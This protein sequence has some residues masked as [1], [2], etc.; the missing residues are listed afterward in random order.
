VT[1]QEFRA[2]V[3]HVL[4]E[5]GVPGAGIALVR[6]SGVEWAGG[7]GYA[8]RDAR[9]PVTARTHFRA[10]SISKTFVAM[11]LVQLSEEGDIHLD[12][13][14]AELAPQLR[15]ENPWQATEP[16]RVIHLLE[17]T[18]GFDDM[19][20][21]EMYNVTDPPDLSLDEVLKINPRSR[22]VR[23][24]PG[25]RMSYSNPGYAAAAYVLEQ[26]TGQKYEDVIR[27]E[28]F[29][30]IGMKTSSFELTEADK[31]I[32]AKG[33]DER[34]GSAVPYSQIYLRPSGNL[35][36][37][38][39]ELGWFVHVLLNWGEIPGK[40][41]VDP[42]YLSNMEHPRTTLAS[43]AGLLNGYGSG[44]RSQSR[45][46][47]PLLGHD[48]GFEG[49]S[50]RYAYSPS[51]DVGFVVLLNA[52]FSS[53]A[54]DRISNLAIQY[55]K[56]DVEPPPKPQMNAEPVFLDRFAGYYH[57]ASP[58]N[59]VIA[60]ATWLLSGQ[61]IAVRDGELVSRPVFGSPQPLIPVGEGL[62]RLAPEVD[63]TRVFATD[64]DEQM[65]LTGVGYAVRQS[66]WRV[67]I[68]R[69][70]VLTASLFLVSPL[71]L[72]FAWMAHA[73]RATPG[74]FWT[75]KAML[76]LTSLCA[77]PLA[78]VTD[79]LDV[80]MFG[81][82][83]PWTATIYASTLLLPLA[84]VVALAATLVARSRGAGRWLLGYAA[85]VS[86]SAILVSVYLY[87]WGM[88]GFKTWDF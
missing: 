16:V 69:V 76:L 3:Q 62:F 66:R 39:A 17:H 57:D 42:E 32:L 4:D 25:T 38:A 28:I 6:Q 68:V 50:S 79:K 1:L 35:H 30:P 53:Q 22:R 49:F 47:F 55:L 60:F 86:C 36:T 45:E 23:W 43:R 44:I 46:P 31:A 77:L 52:T 87:S 26:V 64:V 88:V 27:R 85:A 18:A 10:G 72:V 48:G 7:V 13:P 83:N 58:R 67:E 29:E 11:A 51:R 74:G 56:A 15:I 61:T 78:I 84:G 37:S 82:L 12:S 59:Q 5:T 70:P 65:V 81:Q 40:L 73:T 21:N 14:V 2:A 71:L 80:R 41:I 34:G 75:L 20:F 54:M 8:D 9:T 24:R 33:Y 63:A 19:H